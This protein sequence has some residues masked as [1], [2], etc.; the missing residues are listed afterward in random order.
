M[1]LP[2]FFNNQF[3]F[4]S[5]PNTFFEGDNTNHIIFTNNTKN[6][7]EFLR[8]W[9]N[10]D[11]GKNNMNDT[12][13]NRNFGKWSIKDG[14]L[15]ITL[16]DGK[17]WNY[18]KSELSKIEKFWVD[19]YETEP[20]PKPKQQEKQK[21]QPTTQ[22]NQEEEPKP[23]DTKR[24]KPEFDFEA[25]KEQNKPVQPQKPPMDCSE[26]IDNNLFEEYF[27]EE[28]KEQASKDFVKFYLRLQPRFPES[29][30]TVCGLN[31]DGTFTSGLVHKN[32][33]VRYMTRTR[34]SLTQGDT[35]FN[36]W[37][38]E[39][40]K[41]NSDKFKDETQMKESIVKKLKSIKETKSLKE[42]LVNKLNKKKIE[43]KVN[44]VKV[45]RGLLKLSE[46]YTFKRD[47]KFYSELGRIVKNYKTTPN[48]LTENTDQT[49]S[50][51]FKFVFS[52]GEEQIKK[53]TI[54]RLFKSLSIEEGTE[55]A[56]Q[57]SEKLTAM[58]T[59]KIYLNCLK[60]SSIILSTMI[61]AITS[62]LSS[63]ATGSLEGMVKSVI[64]S[65]LNSSENM[66]KL[67]YQINNVVCPV[68]EGYKTKI[69][70]M[71]KQISNAFTNMI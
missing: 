63:E 67:K 28:F 10:F 5:Y 41:T 13:F 4:K 66:E 9:D 52:N 14:K 44:E 47:D 1:A 17:T 34:K 65:S 11:V 48:F 62:E 20:E 43:K 2:K 57:I 70:D 6:D 71:P 64:N 38:K 18:P 45:E 51:A 49:F 26:W 24:T 54:N 37:L 3:S 68:L 16:N 50:D 27:K 55:I 7:Q 15:V 53:E 58:E 29:F 30:N 19:N 31:S 39:Y 23:V 21:E 56:N 60:V 22:T 35:Y 36:A 33:L 59:T 40:Q 69:V 61:T 32:G 42:S 46:S 8:L 25:W 12:G